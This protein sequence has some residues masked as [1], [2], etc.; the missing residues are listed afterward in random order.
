MTRDPR[1]PGGID[2]D[3]RDEVTVGRLLQE[4]LL[5]GARVLI[6]DADT[7]TV[8]WCHSI[9][10]LED[11]LGDLRAVAMMAD[12][13]EVPPSLVERLAG[14]GAP[15]LFVFNSSAGR[16]SA[17]AAGHG[18]VVVG[19][20]ESATARTLS[21]MVARLSLAYESHVLHYAQRV[22]STLAQLLHRGA[23]V[24]ALCNRMARLSDCAVAVVGADLRLV[25]FDHGPNLWMDPT[26]MAAAIRDIQEHL[27]ADRAGQQ[28]LHEAITVPGGMGERPVTYVAGPIALADRQDGWVV[29][30]EAHH[31]PHQHDLAEHRVVVEQAATIVGTE[32]LRVRSVE[33]AEERARG[34]FV[35]AL[36]HGRF[37]NHADVVARASHHDF[38]VDERYG[39]VI[40]RVTGLIADGDSP[41]RL[42][43]MAREAGRVLP[44]CDRHTM[45]AVVG[46][47]LAIVRQV[48]AQGRTHPDPTIAELRE[49][50]TALER[51]LSRLSQHPMVI[52][53]GRAVTGAEQITESYREARIALDLGERLRVTRVCGFADL[54]V[55]SAL[56]E[57]AQQP[58]G[59][60]FAADILDPLLHDRG[61]ALID[62]AS[63][64]VEAGGN[65]N[66]SSRRLGI[67]RNTMLYKLDRISRLLERDIRE[68]DT[69]FTIWLALRLSRLAATAQGVDRDLSSG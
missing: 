69:Q 39:V 59:A 38:P 64:Y 12:E 66:E 48:S 11:D 33:R 22:H 27:T 14:A 61:G 56:L 25:A 8:R 23:G 63:E 18:M 60:S 53:Y 34:N 13:K 47:V 17:A 30:V 36:L 49:Y 5:R 32:L 46:D 15:A 51:R 29:L 10:D 44:G 7:T 62:V 45:A 58:A 68:A 35:H 3:V 26:M 2:A 1:S 54:R 20:P 50:A 24:D 41:A 42:A 31:P 28:S 67:H 4:R 40:A 37:S 6:G 65:V 21:E 19:L 57:L 55:D 52:A 9:R 43:E 16:W